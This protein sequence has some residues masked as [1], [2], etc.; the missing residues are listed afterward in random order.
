[1]AAVIGPGRVAWGVQLPVQAQSR[2]F[3]EPWEADAGPEEM[4]LV[5]EAADRAG[6]LYVAVCEHIAIPRP[7]D[8][9]MGA[10][11]YHPIATLG[12]LAA[13]TSRTRLL[14]HVAIPAYHHPLELA[15]A[16]ATLDR[17]SGG[18]VIVGVG[19]GHTE[20]E[21]ARL[22]ADYAGRGPKLDEAIAV[23]RAA[24]GDQYPETDGPTWPLDGQ[25]AVPPRPVQA[26][27]PVWVG[28]SSSA[29]VRRAARRGDGWLPQGTRRSQMVEDVARIRAIRSDAGLPDRFDIGANLT[30]L[31][32]GDPD[33]DTG[34]VMSGSADELAERIRRWVDVGANQIQVRLRSRS[35]GELADQTEQFGA[36]VAPL[37]AS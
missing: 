31:Y 3:V 2:L 34:P 13:R 8:E 11:W 23:I 10:T 17:L 9:T 24:L 28:G 35:A 20:G 19:A 21:F 12:Y 26:S 29:A 25:A 15:K 27:V 30:G 5:A 7:L 4:A 22:G 37:L 32:V 18:R 36:Q 6:A 1:M 33:W 14:S 16:F